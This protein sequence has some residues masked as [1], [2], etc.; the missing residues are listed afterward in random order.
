LKLIWNGFLTATVLLLPSF[1]EGVLYFPGF[2][3]IETNLNAAASGSNPYKINCAKKK[4]KEVKK[5]AIVLT[6]T[7]L[8]LLCSMQAQALPISYGTASHYSPAW[9]EL[10]TYDDNGAKVSPY[11]VFWT[12]DNG[13]TWGHDTNL[14]VGQEVQFKFNMHKENVGTH[15][16][17]FM[18][19]WIDWGQDGSFNEPSDVLA[20]GYQELME[21]ESGNIGSWN[22]PN[23]PDYTFLSDSFLLTLDNIGELLLR[24]RVT[25]SHSLANSMGFYDWNDQFDITAGTYYS[26]F[27]PTGWLYQGEVEEWAINVH[28][29]PVPEPATMLL[30]GSGLLGIIGLRRRKS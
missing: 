6:F 12:T 16:A 19:S 24:A 8:I 9:Q 14:F 1:R 23:Q 13:A 20:F 3:S 4:E 30:L 26:G 7:A 2:Q 18:K 5:S 27:N 21:N 29:A 17:D 10:A 11:G 25:C 28:A 15:Y 22:S